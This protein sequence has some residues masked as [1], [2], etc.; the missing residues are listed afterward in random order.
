[1]DRRLDKILDSYVVA[2]AD[3]A[4]LERVV[5]HVQ[6]HKALSINRRK[7]LYAALFSI[8]TLSGFWVGNASIAVTSA[9]ATLQYSYIAQ[10]ILGPVSLS[11]FFL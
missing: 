3:N 4:F 6:E 8:V 7:Y 2:N 9:Q 10:A 5:L 1:M 11:E